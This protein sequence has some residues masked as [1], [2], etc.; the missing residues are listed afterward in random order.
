MKRD[1][2]NI[3]T[4]IYKF[5]FV[6][7]YLLQSQMNQF[8]S[9]LFFNKTDTDKNFEEIEFRI[10]CGISGGIKCLKKKLQ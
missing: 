10:L 8:F 7:L 5:E 3:S 6:Y 9:S 4:F 2:C 1:K